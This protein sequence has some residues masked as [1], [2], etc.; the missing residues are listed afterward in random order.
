MKIRH[1]T[2]GFIYRVRN[3][4]SGRVYIGQHSK[5]Y[6]EGLEPGDIMGRLYFTSNKGL[7]NQWRDNPDAFEF[8]ILEQNITDKR[9]LDFRE[10]QL[11]Y[12]M[13]TDKVPCYNRL[14]NI[15]LAKRKEDEKWMIK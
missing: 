4:I 11:I 14:I 9:Y 3:K 10:A 12:E 15:T 8:E 1:F 5:Y 7:A 6:S 13:W 2:R